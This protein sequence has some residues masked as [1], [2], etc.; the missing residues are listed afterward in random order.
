V[1]VLP[2]RNHAIVLVST[3]HRPTLRAIAYARATRP[4]VLE[5]V[6]VN[7]D[8]TDTRRLIRDWT[9]RGL[10][11]PLK[12]VESPY[13]EITK[14]V[15]DHVARVRTESPRD[16]VTVFIPEYVVGHWW[17]QILHNQS[18]LRLKGRLL[19]QPGVMVTNV[20]CAARLVRTR[21]ATTPGNG[22][23][24]L[25]PRL[26]GLGRSPR[27]ATR[28]HRSERPRQLIVDLRRPR[29]RASP[30]GHINPLSA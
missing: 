24:R 28:V 30:P 16:V 23:R 5:A 9:T 6:T 15:L 10:P 4:D 29:R 11:V 1:D 21:C 18:A 3:L 20:P 26:P 19:F 8:D 17:E 7:V 12:E 25:P 27:R 2:S 22:T 14:P 13:R